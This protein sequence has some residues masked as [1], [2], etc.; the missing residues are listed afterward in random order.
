MVQKITSMERTMKALSF[1]EPDRVPLFFLFSMYGAKEACISIKD[2]FDNPDIVVKTQIYMQEKYCSDCYN[3]ASY[4][5]I[6]FEAFGG[7]VIFSEDGPPNAGKP[8]F[9]NFQDILS[10]SPPKVK[11][12]KCLTKT[13]E[14]INKLKAHSDAV[15]IIGTVVSPFSQPVMQMGFDKYLDLIYDEPQLFIELMKRNEDFCVEWA[16]AQLEAGATVIGYF[17]P[18]SSTSIIPKEVY[19]K[20]GFEVAKR[21]V[22]MI[23]GPTATH[24]ASGNCLGIIDDVSKTGTTAIGVSSKEDIAQIKEKCYGK[25]SVIGNLN[26]IEM[27]NWSTSDAENA[28]KEIIKK[29]SK[30]GGLVIADNHGEIPYQVKEETLLAIAEAINK[31]GQY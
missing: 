16:N 20:T 1:K 27:C 2:Y 23:K 9:S 14:I 8:I 19:L 5:A 29:A 4:A 10:F 28:V 12:T 7:E 6:E 22:S 13:L 25:L 31:W 30:G 26:G 18:V 3:A 21:T 15:P 17:D 24:F 11:Q